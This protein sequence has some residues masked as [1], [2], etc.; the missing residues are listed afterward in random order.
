MMTFHLFRKAVM[1]SLIMS[2][3]MNS[4]FISPLTCPA[5]DM[6][7]EPRIWRLF[8]RLAQRV[9]IK[10]VSSASKPTVQL[11]LFLVPCRGRSLRN[12]VISETAYGKP[13]WHCTTQLGQK[14]DKA[15]LKKWD[16]HGVCSWDAHLTHVEQACVTES[17]LHQRTEKNNKHT[18]ELVINVIY[19]GPGS[20]QTTCISKHLNKLVITSGEE[21]TAG[22]L[23]S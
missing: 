19:F 13:Q 18:A 14:P 2:Q 12:P 3:V 5:L 15:N 9:K 8:L 20:P 7:I 22:S 23:F 16:R 11:L 6:L 10:L 17:S 1:L 21:E 4:W